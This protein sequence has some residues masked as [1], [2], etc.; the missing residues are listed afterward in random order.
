MLQGEEARNLTLLL[1]KFGRLVR[2]VADLMIFQLLRCTQRSSVSYCVCLHSRWRE[3]L[4]D[5]SYP[6]ERP[7]TRCVTGQSFKTDGRDCDVGRGTFEE[8]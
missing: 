6:L 4:C 5:A 3:F 2:V 7:I 8:N 1:C